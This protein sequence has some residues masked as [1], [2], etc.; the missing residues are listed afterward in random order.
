M[1]AISIFYKNLLRF[2][3]FNFPF[4]QKPTTIALVA[5]ILA[6]PKSY[7]T[8]IIKSDVN[9][10]QNLRNVIAAA[11]DTVHMDYAYNS[12]SALSNSSFGP[13]VALRIL[14]LSHNIIWNIEAEAF[15]PLTDLEYINLSHNKLKVLRGNVFEKNGKLK[16]VDLS[17]NPLAFPQLVSS[18]LQKLVFDFCSYI[19]INDETFADVPRVHSLSLIGTAVLPFGE[20]KIRHLKSLSELMLSREDS[21]RCFQRKKY[22]GLAYLKEKGVTVGPDIFCRA[23]DCASSHVLRKHESLTE[24]KPTCSNA[25]SMDYSHNKISLLRNDS[26]IS[27]HVLKI[28]Q[29]NNNLITIIE[30]TT[31]RPLTNLIFIDLS[32]NKLQKIETNTFENN[33]NLETIDLSHNNL[34]VPQ[35]KAYSLKTLKCKFCKEIKI[36]DGIFKTIPNVESIQ[37]LGTSIYPFDQ[38]EIS[39]MSLKEFVVTGPD[40]KKCFPREAY[41]GMQYLVRLNVFLGPDVFCDS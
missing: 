9:R 30:V 10:H 4:Q 17:H 14:V 39:L 6:L 21:K 7:Y 35:I 8:E 23:A 31:F 19:Q 33:I 22:P 24:V 16:T 26:F 41:P 18:S 5:F 34:I 37:L 29:L 1:L 25:L 3:H 40:S 11:P 27:N 28:L 20:S 13:Y 32:N 36:N 2:L 12:I 15:F 38:S